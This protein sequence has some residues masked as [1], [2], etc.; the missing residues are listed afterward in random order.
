MVLGVL[1][2]EQ[3]LG[4]EKNGGQGMLQHP[5]GGISQ[6]FRVFEV[7]KELPEH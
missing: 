5:H 4:G 6:N 7:G 3:E 1:E 2:D